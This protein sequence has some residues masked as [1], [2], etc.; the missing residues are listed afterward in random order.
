MNAE[1]FQGKWMQ[2]KGELM[3]RWG[4]FTDNDLLE[5]EG[6][7]EKLIGKVYERYGDQRDDV[8]HW[9]G[10]WQEESQLTPPDQKGS[11]KDKAGMVKTMIASTLLMVS[12]MVSMSAG[13]AW[14]SWASWALFESKKDLVAVAR[15]PL[16]EAVKTA[17]VAVP[18]KAIEAEIT[19]DG[20]K[21]VYEIEI[22]DMNNATRKVYVDAQTRVTTIIR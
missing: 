22:I 7:Y 21:T 10:E 6:S 5:V 4:R 14:A 19:K 15:I 13:P 9:V 2:F 8:I 12:I 20:D 16:E 18:G 1:Q 3:Q 11:G 17:L